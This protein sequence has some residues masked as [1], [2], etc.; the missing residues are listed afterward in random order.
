MTPV[1]PPF[2]KA[3]FM[4]TPS[5]ELSPA[6]E[7]QAR[8]HVALRLGWLIHATVFVLVNAGLWLAGKNGGWLGLPTGGWIIGLLAHGAVVWLQPLGQGIRENMLE[9]ERQR[10][11]GH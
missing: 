4:N 5:T 2:K 10:L 6:L 8:R 11:R 3:F 1:Q 7:K 9:K